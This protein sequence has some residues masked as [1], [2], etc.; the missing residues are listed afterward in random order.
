ML[1]C[2]RSFEIYVVKPGQSRKKLELPPSLTIR[3][4]RK[5]VKD[6]TGVEPGRQLLVYNGHALV[7]KYQE[8]QRENTVGNI[9]EFKG[10]VTLTNS[11]PFH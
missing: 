5:R 4:L 9:L 1:A 3:E 6:R 7:D 2:Y 8:I 10:N 11:P